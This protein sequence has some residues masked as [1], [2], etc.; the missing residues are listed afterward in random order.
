MPAFIKQLDAAERRLLWLDDTDYTASLLAGG[1]PPWLDAA[2]FLAWRR[3]AQSLLKPDVATLPVARVCAAWLH[4]DPQLR[5]DMA[6]RSRSNFPLKT[7]LASAQL[8]HHLTELLAGMR[9]S[10][11]GLTLA[12]LCPSPRAWVGEAYRWAFGPQAAVRVGEG[13]VDAA[14]LHCA[15]FLREFAGVGL[16]SVLLEES[17]ECEPADA[18]ELEWY[19][20]VLNVGAHYRWDMGLRL[21]GTG[22][23]G[24]MGDAAARDGVGG[25]AFVIASRP[26]TAARAGRIIPENFWRGSPLEG[27][28]HTDFDFSQVPA[29]LPPEVILDRLSVLRQP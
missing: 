2:A 21:T 24:E 26:F 25:F 5:A 6:S 19:R 20:S 28:P 12:L 13:E 4:R 9:S 18:T 8:R 15:D 14:T 27:P 29:G 3:K 1:D 7:L 22:F 23:A 16:D 10:F 11:P 17:N